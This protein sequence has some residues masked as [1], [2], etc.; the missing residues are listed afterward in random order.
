MIELNHGINLGGFLSQCEH[1]YEH[2]D[3]FIGREDIFNIKSM[4]FDHV[5]LPVDCNVFESEDGTP[6]ERGLSYVDKVV[7]WCQDAGLNMII[8]LHKAYGYDFN[9]AG[10][11][12]GDSDLPANTLFDDEGLQSRF[13]SLWGRIAAR[14]GKYNFV[15]FEL[16]N[17]VVEQEN[18]DKWNGLIRRT[19]AAIREHAPDNTIIYGGI[20]WNSISYIKY[21]GKPI[22]DNIIYTFHFY[23]P[24][25]FTHQKAHWVKAM[26]P[27]RE[28]YYPKDMDYYKEISKTL[29]FQG[30]GVL[31]TKSANMGEEFLEEMIGEGLKAAEEL[32]AK[33]YCGEFGVIDKAP[34]DDT[35]RWFKDVLGLFGRKNIG[36]CIW[37]YKDKDFSF[38]DAPNIE[39]VRDEI[40]KLIK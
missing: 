40:L 18:T 9:S 25:I 36:W 13:I 2:Y 1:S 27:N 6:D 38:I 34:A 17:E 35:L 24:L 16:L 11:G 37:N 10:S 30:A 23:E 14:Y 3:T 19:V 28:V 8:D 39:P 20:C 31:E 12:S 26:D 7:M 21:L 5:R 4:G 33:L 32:G 29:G 15:A 22:D